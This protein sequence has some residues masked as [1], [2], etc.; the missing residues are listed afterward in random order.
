[1]V[2]ERV[3]LRE[4]RVEFVPVAGERS[5]SDPDYWVDNVRNTV[6]FAEGVARLD[7]AHVVE[8]GPDAALTPFLDGGIPTQRKDTDEVGG[9]LRGAGELWTRGHSLDW[10]AVTGRGSRGDLPTYAFQRDRYWVKQLPKDITDGWRYRVD[11]TTVGLPPAEPE[12]TWAVVGADTG[13]EATAIAEAVGGTATVDDATGGV[14]AVD[15]SLDDLLALVQRLVAAGS[16]ARLWC[17]TTRPSAGVHGFGRAVALEQ[18]ALWGGSIDVQPGYRTADLRA[19]LAQTSEDQLVLGP[20]GV[21]A[22]RLVR[23]AAPTASWKPRGTVLVTGGLGA[24]GSHTAR[25]CAENGAEHLLLLGRR[26]LDT[27]G[28]AELRDELT[29]LG[30]RVTVEAC[31]AADRDELHALLTRHPVDAVI[32][33]AGVLDD[34]VATDLTPERVANVFRP[35]VDAA[36]LLDELTTGLDAFVLFTSVSGVT[37]SAAQAHYAAANAELDVLAERRLAAGEPATAIAW[38]AWAGGGMAA[39]GPASGRVDRGGVTPMPPAL[40]VRA[41]GKAVGDG[42]VV[43]ADIDWERFVPAFTASRPSTV[44]DLIHAPA[45]S[46]PTVGTTVGPEDVDELVRSCTAGV[47]AYPSAADVPPGKAFRDLGI[48]S[49]TALELRNVL[50]RATGLT[51]PATLVFDF[52]TPAALTVHLAELLGGPGGTREI[53]RAP[54]V[55]DDPIAI[56]SMACRF[57]GGVSS[58]EEFWELL[59]AGG[60]ALGA[61][62]TDRGWDLDTLLA[63]AADGPGVSHTAEGGFLADVAG[64]DAELFGISPR[65]ALAMDPQQRLLLQTTWEAFERGGLDPRSVHGS[66][67]GV[68][69]GTNGQDYATA[70]GDDLSEYGGYLATGNAASVVSGRLSYS[71]GLEGPSLTVDTACSASLVSLHLAAQSLRSGECDLAI[72]GGVTVMSTPA[73]FVE[74]SRQRG[75]AGDGRC[76]AFSDDAD[77]TGWGEGVGMLLVE[78]LSDAQRNGHPVLAVLRG[79]AV[80]QD[81]ASNGLTAPNGPAQQ[82]VIRS[83]LAS[84]DLEPSEVDAV[85]AHGTGTTLGDPIEAQALLAAYGGNRDRPLWLGSV[86]S[87]I[88]HTQAAA[89]VAGVIKSVLALRHGTLPRTL[90]VNEPNRH[91]DWTTGSVSLLTEPQPLPETERPRRIG[92]SSFGVSG[93]N[94]HLV[95]EQVPPALPEPETAGDEPRPRRA[96]PWV[97]SGHTADAVRAQAERLSRVEAEPVDVAHTLLTTRA[98]L[99]HTGV[100]IGRDLTDLRSALHTIRPVEAV[101]GRTAFVFTGQG[102]QRVGMGRQLA[103]VFPVFAEA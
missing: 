1:S 84:A 18:P 88:G 34:G 55:A 93:T 36:L 19:A 24:A 102:S 77:G 75:L 44:F 72:A 5:P 2:V 51:L 62:P 79:S 63:G 12:G 10:T 90:H 80:N 103:S 37:G 76:K 33:T 97:V 101:S 99:D 47:L 29:A 21:S 40:A 85:E 59:A 46:G 60:D 49:L 35:K 4:P 25:W 20:Q 92:V 17:V 27:P 3:E 42:C 31:D 94:A 58:V 87:N 48:D 82:R 57:P 83:A 28:A 53:T 45:P 100:A 23:A 9:V 7:A 56:V 6:R 65:E 98:A 64:F 70:L 8:V 81:G 13:D 54:A 69:V 86:K 11:W 22:R 16:A 61:F 95:V 91:V 14:V 68:F 74:F 52:P 71:F 73:V 43:V 41:L 39:E 96:V 66:A 26:G 89:G 67:T 15:P 30:T 78:R 38:G 50:T 32:H